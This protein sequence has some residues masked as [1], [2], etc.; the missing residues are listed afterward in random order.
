MAAAEAA[1]PR[2]RRPLAAIAVL[3]GAL[4]GLAACAAPAARSAAGSPQLTVLPA[5]SL[6]RLT[7]ASRAALADE[8]PG[9]AVTLQIDATRLTGN[10]G[11]NLYGADYRFEGERLLIEPVVATRRACIGPG[12]GIEMAY[13]EALRIVQGFR[14]RDGLLL[15]QLADGR[16]LAFEPTAHGEH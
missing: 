11:C 5:G 4:S 14:R 9:A 12:A 10:G 8:P 7:E 13:F 16:E 1:P 15:M 3:A 6:W 2:R